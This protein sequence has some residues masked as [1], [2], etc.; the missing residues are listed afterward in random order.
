M[1]FYLVNSDRVWFS[2]CFE[3]CVAI[4]CFTMSLP[5][6]I[7]LE[8]ELFFSWSCLTA[9]EDPRMF[10]K[11]RTSSWYFENASWPS[12]WSTNFKYFSLN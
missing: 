3:S 6:T 5:Y 10:F 1:H 12:F 4:N 11:L 7:L 9:A 2:R 8:L